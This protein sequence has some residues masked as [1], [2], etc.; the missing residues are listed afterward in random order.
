MNINPDTRFGVVSGSPGRSPE[1]SS[2]S[3]P[4]LYG[5]AVTITLH[6]PA[7]H[8]T[9]PEVPASSPTAGSSAYEQ[10]TLVLV[11]LPIAPALPQKLSTFKTL[12]VGFWSE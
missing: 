9:L 10:A 6:I 4:A 5:T 11:Q 12:W 3:K 1:S 7:L 2:T 8:F